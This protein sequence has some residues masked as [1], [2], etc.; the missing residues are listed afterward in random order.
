MSD[1]VIIPVEVEKAEREQAAKR[2]EV[3]DFIASFPPD[4]LPACPVGMH[5]LL[6][7]AKASPNSYELA[8]RVSFTGVNGPASRHPKWKAYV[9]HVTACADCSEAGSQ[10][11][12][13]N[14]GIIRDR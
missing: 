14:G 11:I 13:Y 7:F 3:Q 5:L 2:D 4:S 8:R 1:R 6:D 9:A 12:P 10:P